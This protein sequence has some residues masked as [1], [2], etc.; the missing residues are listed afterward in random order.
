MIERFKQFIEQEDLFISADKILLAVSGG[1]DSVVMVHLF[2]HAGFE[3]EIAHCNFNLRG[4]ESDEDELFVKGNAGCYDKKFHSKRFDTQQFA[5]EHKL[6]I[7]EAARELR[8]KWF[9]EIMEKQN[10]QYI[11]TAH[12]LDDSVETVILNLVKGTGIKGLHGV[13]TKN[14]KVIRP[15]LFVTRDK[16]LNYAKEKE[17]TYREDSSNND[18]KYS[19][20]LIRSKVIPELEQVNPSFTK[21]FSENI[22]RFKEVERIY[23]R[24]IEQLKNELLIEE[25]GC[26]KVDIEA[27]KKTEA[28][29]TILYEMLKSFDFNE[30]AQIMSVLDEQPGKRF[31]SKTHQLVKDRDHLIISLLTDDCFDEII[32]E[33]DQ[34]E[35]EVLEKKL[36][37]ETITRDNF[38]M[39]EDQNRACLDKDKLT[40]PLKI[41]KWREGDY[42]YP[43]GMKQKKKLSDFLI[44]EK[45][46]LNEKSNQLVLTSKED[47]VWVVSRRI[48]ERYKII[49]ETNWTLQVTLTDK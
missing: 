6:S 48:D 36:S 47:I 1:V 11:A 23:D 22:D 17:L 8:Y 25:D 21:T 28:P 31:F 26:Y 9:A 4:K 45:V 49:D 18:L 46:P 27:L 44:D 24:R 43:L 42:F 33:Q 20:N 35:V 37:I 41:R 38:K 16:I 39:K 13:P 40:F 7:Q 3:F 30:V 15:L 10:L 12:H 5:D 14:G 2:Y 19:R 29:Q 32:I 34:M